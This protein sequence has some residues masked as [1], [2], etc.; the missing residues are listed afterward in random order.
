MLGTLSGIP[1]IADT[2]LTQLQLNMTSPDGQTLELPINVA[3][4]AQARQ[5]LLLQP[6][7][8]RKAAVGSLFWF[9]AGQYF[10]SLNEELTYS[11]SSP[12]TQSF[13]IGLVL[14]RLN[15]SPHSFPA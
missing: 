3:V 4:R 15:A 10:Q 12:R 14:L 13:S 7:S 8:D 9:P 6:F 5:P 2:S 1:T 11:L